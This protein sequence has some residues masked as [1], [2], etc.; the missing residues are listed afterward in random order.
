[1]G[2][3]K[4][5]TVKAVELKNAG[6][7]EELV[8]F[9]NVIIRRQILEPFDI[10]SFYMYRGIA[11]GELGEID[12][13]INDLNKAIELI[14]EVLANWPGNYPTMYREMELQSRENIRHRIEELKQRKT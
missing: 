3:L 7:Y 2:Y 5:I 4:D 9:C 14:N 13:A 12:N 1:M 8:Q 6:Q 11:Y 10:K